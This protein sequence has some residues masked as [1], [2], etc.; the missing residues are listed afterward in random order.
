[1][2]KAERVVASSFPVY[3][4][5]HASKSDRAYRKYNCLVPVLD[6]K[7]KNPELTFTSKGVKSIS[8]HIS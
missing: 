1:M 5:R 7:F 3:E 4:Q 8:D 6:E 2:I